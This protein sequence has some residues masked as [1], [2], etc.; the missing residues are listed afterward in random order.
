MKK[1]LTLSLFFIFLTLVACQQKQK[2]TTPEESA[3]YREDLIKANQYLVKQDAATIAAFVKRHNWQMTSTKTG[4][5]YSVIEKGS[6][7]AVE[8]GCDVTLKYKISLLDGTLCYS[9]DSLGPKT[10]RVT[11]GGVESGLEEGVLLLHQGDKARFIMPPHL[12]HGLIGDQ[13]KIPARASIVYEVEIINIA[14]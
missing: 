4:L 8:K 13:N 12:A 14:K 9:S 10:F 6:G 3:Q 1:H 7:P 2:Q 5:W 11:Q